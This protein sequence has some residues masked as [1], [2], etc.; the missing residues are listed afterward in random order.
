M[1]EYDFFIDETNNGWI[2]GRPARVENKKA[3]DYLNQLMVQEA[4]RQSGWT[5]PQSLRD[6]FGVILDKWQHQTPDQ[7][8]RRIY[9]PNAI[10][11]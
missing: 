4:L 3:N 5:E 7:Q 11:F 6:W 9:F 2:N 10:G 8:Q 1:A